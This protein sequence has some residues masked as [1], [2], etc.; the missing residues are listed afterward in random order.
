MC[1]QSCDE[2]DACARCSAARTGRASSTRVQGTSRVNEHAR[3]PW[4]AVC[5]AL[6]RVVVTH[7]EAPD[8][9]GVDD[10]DERER[11]P[12]LAAATARIAHATLRSRGCRI[13]DSTRASASRQRCRTAERLPSAG[14]RAAPRTQCCHL[15]TGD[16]GS[17]IRDGCDRGRGPRSGDLR[18]LPDLRQVT[19]NRDQGNYS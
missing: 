5:E 16:R 12:L 18:T 1:T 4:H 2:P 11:N 9:I 6:V 19:L 14:R 3:K 10:G 15:G 17:L 8:G 13:R 7:R